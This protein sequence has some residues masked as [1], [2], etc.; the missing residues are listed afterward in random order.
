MLAKIHKNVEGRIILALCDTELIRKKFV[1]GDLQI[2]LTSEFYQGEEKTEDEIK[3]MIKPVHVINAVGE[4]S[5]E[6]LKKLDLV[7]NIITIAGVPH[8]EVILVKDE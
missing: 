4:K 2:D 1:E 7:E 8:A 3:E 6:L 5:I